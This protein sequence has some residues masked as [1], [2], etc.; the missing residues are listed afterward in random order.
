MS[1]LPFFLF[2]GRIRQQRSDFGKQN[3][4]IIGL[5]QLIVPTGAQA[6][7]NIPA[8]AERRQKEDGNGIARFQFPE[9]FQAAAV[10]QHDIQYNQIGLLFF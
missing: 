3:F 5:Y 9:K 8:C 10:W 4:Q 6:I 7:H 1:R 2:G